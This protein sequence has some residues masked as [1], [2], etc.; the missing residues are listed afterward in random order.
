MPGPSNKE[1]VAALLAALRQ[2]YEYLYFGGVLYVKRGGIYKPLED[3]ILES[4]I[5]LVRGPAGVLES[6]ITSYIR[7]EVSE[8]LKSTCALTTEEFN[9]RDDKYLIAFANGY[10]DIRELQA[11]GAVRIH[12][13]ADAGSKIFIQSIP[14]TVLETPPAGPLQYLSEHAPAVHAF[15]D[16]LVGGERMLLQLQK[17]GYCFLRSNPYKRIFLEYGPADAG[18]TT[19]MNFLH[20]ILAPENV[21]SVKMQD[22][23]ENSFAGADLFGKLA[24]LCDDL[25][26]SVVNSTGVIK[27]LSGES[28]FSSDR[29][30]RSRI[31]FHNYAKLIFAANRL[32]FLKEKDDNAFFSRVLITEYTNNFPRNPDFARRLHTEASASA[33]ITAGLLGLHTLL[34]SGGFAED[35]DVKEQWLRDTNSVHKFVAEKLEAGELIRSPTVFISRDELYE[36]YCQFCAE[37]GK[38]AMEKNSMTRTLAAVFGVSVKQKSDGQHRYYAYAGIGKPEG[39]QQAPQAQKVLSSTTPTPI[40]QKTPISAQTNASPSPNPLKPLHT[41]GYCPACGKPKELYDTGA[42]WSCLD[43]WN[44]RKGEEAE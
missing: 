15:L 21:C 20:Y 31:S 2:T 28:P 10:V 5:Q 35:A 25:P 42:G 38:S 30:H 44:E 23:S 24:D 18:K 7:K 17:I 12:P 6:D 29:K 1:I 41:Q 43:C 36:D 26:S 16:S 32:P 11:T 27:M 39:P 4:Q 22:L 14:H 33:A 37:E 13:F 9:M 8:H 34:N 19:F 3:H 40:V